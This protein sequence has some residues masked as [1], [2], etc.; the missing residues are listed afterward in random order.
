MRSRISPA[1][2]VISTEPGSKTILLSSCT[3]TMSATHSSGVGRD[4]TGSSARHRRCRAGNPRPCPSSSL[5]WRVSSARSAW[6]PVRPRMRRDLGLKRHLPLVE[7]RKRAQTRHGADRPALRQ[8]RHR[9]R[10]Q[11]GALTSEERDG[12]GLDRCADRTRPA[13]GR[14]AAHAVSGS[15]VAK[16]RAGPRPA[17][18]ASGR[19]PSSVKTS[20]RSASSSPITRSNSSCS[21]PCAAISVTVASLND[22]VP[23][24]SST[25]AASPVSTAAGP[26]GAW[27]AEADGAVD[28]S[29]GAR[30][31]RGGDDA[32]LRA[33]RVGGA[34]VE[35]QPLRIE[36]RA[37]LERREDRTRRGDVEDDLDPRRLASLQ[38]RQ[39]L[40]PAARR[41]R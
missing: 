26:A 6:S 2:S 4:A 20:G 13:A 40:P 16:K 9:A 17:S 37:Q 11:I 23:P 12:E 31:A 25:S 21:V 3:A 22:R 18:V 36:N 41:C 28:L 32:L 33:R 15:S 38:L 35:A 39:K 27:H 10:G 34:I 30:R 19:T 8:V 29:R 7:C 5:S 14:A 24:P 1:A